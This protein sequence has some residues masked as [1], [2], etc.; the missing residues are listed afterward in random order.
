M[1][2]SCDTSHDIPH[3]HRL[4]RLCFDCWRLCGSG[5]ETAATAT[6]G[7]NA[8]GLLCTCTQGVEWICPPT[9]DEPSPTLNQTFAGGGY[10]T[11]Q[12]T[13]QECWVCGKGLGC[14]TSK[15]NTPAA[16]GGTGYAGARGEDIWRLCLWCGKRI[17]VGGEK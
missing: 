17:M 13:M 7:T 11:E 6:G 1:C 2:A 15:W 9:H 4:R 5:T 12:H 8:R 10:Q 3:S 14:G 16:L